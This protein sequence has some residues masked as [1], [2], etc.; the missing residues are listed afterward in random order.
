MNNQSKIGAAWLLAGLAGILTVA[1]RAAP[2]RNTMDA[3][4]AT[5]AGLTPFYIGTY[6]RQGSR[7]I[8]LAALD[9][10]TGK[11]TPATPRL[12]AEIRNPSFLCADPHGRF[13]YA[14]SEIPGQDGR[15]GGAAAAFAI[16]AKTGALRPL[17]RVSAHGNSAP[18]H[19]SIDA[20][21]RAVITANY[22]SGTVVSFPVREDGSLG[23]AA[24]VIQHRGSS[25]HPRQKGPHA[26]SVFIAP[27]NRF[28][29]AADLGIDRVVAYRLE[30]ATA[31]LTPAPEADAVIAPGSGPRHLAFDADGTHMYVVTE[32]ANTVVVFARDPRTGKVTELQTVSTLPADF[33]GESYCADIHISPDGRFLYASNRGHNSLAVF[34]ISP[35]DG[36]LDPRGRVPCGGDH[37]RNFAIDPSGQWLLCANQNA[38]NIVLFRLDPKTGMPEPAGSELSIPL[39]VCI[40][41]PPNDG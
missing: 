23:P 4:A 25:V 36:R 39:P 27:D 13:L 1:G 35:A 20:T 21:G 3:T 5:A 12:V 41:F 19:I 22:R 32:L 30:P 17:N 28:A 29:Y 2:R 24:S 18:C 34:A 14:V 37:P 40:L 11:L 10:A 8:Y 9:P 6:T 33:A 38:N 31:V 16:D 15:P 26:H 7:G